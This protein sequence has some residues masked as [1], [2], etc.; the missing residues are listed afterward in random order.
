LRNLVLDH[1][2][3]LKGR[4]KD[5]SR[6]LQKLD[7]ENPV[8]KLKDITGGIR[9]FYCSVGVFFI[10]MAVVFGGSYLFYLFNLFGGDKWVES[11]ANSSAFDMAFSIH[12]GILEHPLFIKIIIAALGSLPTIFS[13]RAV[14]SL[15]FN[16]IKIVENGR[17][18]RRITQTADEYYTLL[19]NKLDE[20]QEV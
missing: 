14:P 18:R 4:V 12:F 20:Y 1:K 17:R 9:F 5:K 16:K 2:D 6:E 19:A 13:A 15:G 3:A 8:L 10:L 7:P 11:L